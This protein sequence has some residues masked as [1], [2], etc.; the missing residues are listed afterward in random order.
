VIFRKTRSSCRK[1][2]R[3]SSSQIVCQVRG[4][5]SCGFIAGTNVEGL[6]P[7][8]FFRNFPDSGRIDAGRVLVA[9]YEHASI[10]AE[11]RTRDDAESGFYAE[12]VKHT[13]H[14]GDGGLELRSPPVQDNRGAVASRPI[15]SVPSTAV[16]RK[17]DATR[18]AA[19]RVSRFVSVLCS[20][21]RREHRR[22]MGSRSPIF[23]RRLLTLDSLTTGRTSGLPTTSSTCLA[24]RSVT[25][26]VG[27]VGW[28]G[29]GIGWR[30][31]IKVI[32]REAAQTAARRQLDEARRMPQGG[33]DADGQP[34]TVRRARREAIKCAF[35]QQSRAP[36][37]SML[38][39]VL[40]RSSIA[41]DCS[42]EGW[43]SN[44]CCST[45]R[46][47]SSTFGRANYGPAIG[48]TTGSHSTR[49]CPSIRHSVP[50]WTRPPTSTDR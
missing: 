41:V 19:W 46:T 18:R 27:V 36:R 10:E 31:D 38:A 6:F 2:G 43:D 44:D 29:E 42:V 9:E 11:F 23:L 14:S 8:P 48:R 5:S 16:D 32:V 37:E 49:T 4:R 33:E 26:P 45:F 13:S 15:D 21:S 28:F 47:E 12:L 25:M 7:L 3:N 20:R 50:M 30:E 24:L 39:T 35:R 34:D 40:V 22:P 17:W 1:C